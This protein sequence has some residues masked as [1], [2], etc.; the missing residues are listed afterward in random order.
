MQSTYEHRQNVGKTCGKKATIEEKE[1]YDY[2]KD[3]PNAK[4]KDIG[5]ALG[6]EPGHSKKGPFAYIYDMKVWKKRE[7]IWKGTLTYEELFPENEIPNSEKNSA[8]GI[9]IAEKNSGNPEK[10]P[11]DF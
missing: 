11:F 1:L 9:L 10:I 6:A 5:E 7:D 4:G 8:N 2:I 3:H